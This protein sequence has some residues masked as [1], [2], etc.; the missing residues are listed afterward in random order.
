MTPTRLVSFVLFLFLALF[1]AHADAQ[2]TQN[3]T[4]AVFTA[5]SQHATSEVTSYTLEVYEGSTLARSNTIG[6][7]TPAANGDIAVP[8]T[9]TGLAA[10][11]TY[12][13]HIVTVGPGGSTR[14][15]TPSNPFVFLN[16]PSAATNLRAQ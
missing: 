6:K 3:P 13:F 10:N 7:P 4:Q 2:T 14:S 8:L 12:T 1:A 5:S 15:A 16:P 9:I 11:K